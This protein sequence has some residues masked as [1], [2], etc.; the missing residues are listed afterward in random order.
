MATWVDL[1]SLL[2]VNYRRSFVA[3]VFMS[4]RDRLLLDRYIA[5]AENCRIGAGER[6]SLSFS[7]IPQNFAPNGAAPL[8][9]FATA[10]NMRHE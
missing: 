8:A 6:G 2:D 10:V 7:K 4:A 9:D 3:G 5:T 1:N